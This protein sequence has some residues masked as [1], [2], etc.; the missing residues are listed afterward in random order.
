MEKK[1]RSKK[2]KKLQIDLNKEFHPKIPIPAVSAKQKWQP[3]GPFP[4][5][6]PPPLSPPSTYSVPAKNLVFGDLQ[7]FRGA[8]PTTASD[9]TPATND[10]NCFPRGFGAA[11]PLNYGDDSALETLPLLPTSSWKRCEIPSH[12]LAP[13]TMTIFYSGSVSAFHDISPEKVEL[14]LGMAGSEEIEEK[15]WNENPSFVYATDETTT[16]PSSSSGSFYQNFAPGA[17]AMARKATLARFLEKRK[18]RLIHNKAYLQ[19]GKVLPDLSL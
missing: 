10:V 14:V 3:F 2:C 12:Q 16:A 17:I 11:I 19:D 8:S 9:G 1:Q 5:V 18:H 7:P 15:R 4:C 6:L 13:S